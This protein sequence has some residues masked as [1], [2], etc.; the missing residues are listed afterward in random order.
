FGRG[1]YVRLTEKTALT[2]AVLSHTA[3]LLEITEGVAIVRLERYGSAWDRFEVDTPNSVL[4][5]KQDGLYRINVRGDRDSEAIIHRGSAEVSSADGTFTVGEGQRLTVDTNPNGRLEIAL[6][7][8]NDDWDRWSYDRDRNTDYTYT[9]SSPSYV[10]N[11]ETN[12]NCFYGASELINYG[13]WSNLSNYGYCWIPRVSTGWAPYRYGQWHFIPRIGW[14][15]LANEPWGWAPYHYGRWV[16]V[17]G[18]WA[19]APGF[20]GNS[21]RYEHS[22]Y[23]WRPALVGFF[24]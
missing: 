22:Y 3:A 12:F 5:L 21:Y 17:N 14:T 9:S 6:D 10:V 4:L 2:I 20:Y 8:S 16:N 18:F 7:T 15:L 1:N 11:Y 13:S 23:Q 24:N 19:W